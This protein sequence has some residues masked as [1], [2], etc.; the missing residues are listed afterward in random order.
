M[1]IIQKLSVVLLFMVVLQA[2]AQTADE[3]IATYFE[4]IGG[5]EKLKSI[6][7]MKLTAKV[8]QGGME[9]PVE[10]VYLKD[11]RQSTSYVVQGKNLKDNVFDGEILWST[12]FMSMKA[13]KSD[14]EA[15]ANFKLDANDFPDPFI[16]YKEKGYT[17]ELMGKE[18][19]DGAETFKIKLVQEPVTIDGKKEE[20]IS[21]YY[22]ETESFV[23][24]VMQT[25]VKSGEAKGM[26]S[27][28][29]F[30]DYQ[31]VDGLYFPFS[32]TQGAKGQPGSP[33]VVQTIELDSEIDASIFAFPEETTTEETTKEK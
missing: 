25:E 27:E 30:G 31:E 28:V 17:V 22:F 32:I 3:I 24:L 11:G 14:A 6:K 33:I 4:N 20:S 16:D 1:K 15:T 12:N 8:N 29:V 5:L 13:E 21:Y 7:S 10:V 18:T 23:P 9:F 19:M 26:I 2:H